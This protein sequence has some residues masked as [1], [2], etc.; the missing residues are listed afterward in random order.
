MKMG[1]LK[2]SDIEYEKENCCSYYGQTVLQQNKTVLKEINNH[3]KLELQL[4]VA[5]SALLER[6]GSAVDY[7]INDGFKII[8]KVYNVLE[9]ENLTSAAKTTGLGIV[10]LV[11]YLKILNLMLLLPLQIDM[12]LCPLQ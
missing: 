7:I 4:I 1:F 12:K 8:A 6:Y 3:A 9:G 11:Q 5:A 10:E 2:N